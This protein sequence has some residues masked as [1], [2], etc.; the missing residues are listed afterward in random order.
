MNGETVHI[1]IEIDI[2]KSF[3]KEKKVGKGGSANK[4]YTV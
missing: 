2:S 3:E 4:R 1:Y